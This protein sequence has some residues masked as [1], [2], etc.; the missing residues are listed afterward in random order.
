MNF[1]LTNVN[2]QNIASIANEIKQFKFGESQFDSFLVCFL[3]FA[4]S[5]HDSSLNY[6]KLAKQL[7]NFT[8]SFAKTNRVLKFSDELV[9][10]LHL[11]MD[12]FPKGSVK[13]YD[14][15]SKP[16]AT[17]SFIGNLYGASFL[18][19][20][21]LRLWMSNLS[22][23]KIKTPLENL[24]RTVKRKV[25]QDLETAGNDSTLLSIMELINELKIENG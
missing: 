7:E 16:V 5:E 15:L 18:T 20:R 25:Q 12:D 6:A 22:D 19:P 10:V 1:L 13:E 4:I 8:V 2:S 23:L 9:R 21:L 3:N 11:A 14:L 24:A 17:T